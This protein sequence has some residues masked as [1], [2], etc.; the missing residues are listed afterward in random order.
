MA[1][2]TLDPGRVWRRSW[3]AAVR[4]D[5]SMNLSREAP[6]REYGVVLTGELVDH[7]LEVD[8]RGG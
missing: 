2:V 7:S 8:E 6:E 1:T 3:P 4:D 5:A